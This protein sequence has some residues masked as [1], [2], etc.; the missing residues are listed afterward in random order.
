MS[1]G[2]IMITPCK[3]YLVGPEHEVSNRVLRHY[4]SL[5]LANRFIRVTFADEHFQ[6]IFGDQLSPSIATRVS[7]F[8]KEGIN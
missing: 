7:K 1:V 6:P 3:T 5:S 8:L 4:S 2:R